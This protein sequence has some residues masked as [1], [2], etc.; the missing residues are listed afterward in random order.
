MSAS[1]RTRLLAAFLALSLSTAVGL[2][3]Y[4]LA[5]LE[6]YGLR[7][8]EERLHTE[9]LLVAALVGPSA[10]EGLS[11]ID[12]TG[13]AA[14][15]AGVGPSVASRVRVLDARGRT[16]ADSEGEA[17]GTDHSMRSEV[18][19]AAAGRYGAATRILADGRVALYVATPVLAGDVVVGTAYV[20]STT[21]SVRTLLRDY[22]LRL[23][24]LAALFAIVALGVAETLARW[25]SRPL[26]ELESAAG[27]FAADHTARVRPSGARETRAVG[28]AFN[29][30]AAE[31]EG[32]MSELRGEEERRS[33]FISD[34]SHELRTPLTAI[35]GAAETLAGGDVPAP[36]AAR[37]L[38][39]IVSES[40]RLSR[41]AADLVA[42]QRIEGATGELPLRRVD[43]GEVTARALRALEH[44]LEA[45][46]VRATVQGQAPGILGDPDRLQQ[47][48]ANLVDNA[49]RVT[50]EGG[51]VNIALG[52][53]G[54]AATLAVLDEGPGV[55]PGDLQR[56]FDRF[57]RAD[58]SRERGSGGSGLGL[59]IVKAIVE[60]HAGTI[61][62]A[63]RPGGGAAFTARFPSLPQD[64][65]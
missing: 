61:E 33:R 30:M 36:D 17:R 22:R 40:D 63:P 31:V 1:I 64:R 49:S 10:G 27:A 56:I 19:R 41:L 57:Y 7:K 4:F 23:A 65:P 38:G 20:S 52:A 6:S 26:R 16:V 24:A 32:A 37:F 44:V 14:R 18:A 50:A 43:L 51:T 2:S 42:L 3:L 29:A 35:R 21:F 55:S 25:L 53:D 58:A 62:A 48:V 47:V 60:A 8:L 39:T 11:S 15:L 12:A 9:A 45:R 46:G 54:P 5:E 59:S 34:V 28:A 13:L